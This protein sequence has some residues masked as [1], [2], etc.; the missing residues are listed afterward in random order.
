MV[1]SII[2]TVISKT[3]RMFFI[4]L[5]YPVFRIL[6]FK[7]IYS[8]S[9]TRFTIQNRNVFFGYYDI[10]PFSNDNKKILACST[11]KIKGTIKPNDIL[12][13]GYFN[14]NNPSVFNKVGETRSWCWQQGARLR[15]LSKSN[16]HIAYNKEINDKY[17]CLIQDINTK[18]IIEKLSCPI[19]DLNS[20]GDFGLSL[21]FSRLQ[22]LRPGYGYNTFQDTTINQI[23]PKDDGI[24]LIDV[25]NNKSKLIVSL[26]SIAKMQISDPSKWIGE[27]YF[28][29]ICFNPRGDRFMF[30][31]LVYNGKNRRSRLITSDLNGENLYI[32]ENDHIVSHYTW[33]NNSQLL[34]TTITDKG[35]RY[36][37]YTDQS[38]HTEIVGEDYLLKDGH[39]S[40]LNNDSNYIL[41]DTYPDIYNDQELLLYNSK[42]NSL[43]KIGRFY[44][45]T[46]FSGEFRCDLHPRIN[47]DNSMICFDS[48]HKGGRRSMYIIHNPI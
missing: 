2:K 38:N 1:I 42:S 43:K 33:K 34:I 17:G 24:F 47:A 48:L 28:N 27:H 18:K 15:W 10:E 22:R 16:N 19:Y 30:F 14:L 13:I 37:L 36:I 39:P 8:N 5:V 11:K 44:N 31:H 46:G 40:F 26:D 9:A 35:L 4:Y 12:D 29:H 23:Y 3:L 41:T 20:T 7:W 6:L 45:S 32:L 21:N 25:N